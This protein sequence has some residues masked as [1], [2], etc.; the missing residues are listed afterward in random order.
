MKLLNI[1]QLYLELSHNEIIKYI[2]IIFYYN[3]I[4]LK[5]SI[6]FI[7]YFKVTALNCAIEHEYIDIVKL[8]LSNENID[9]NFPYISKNKIFINEISK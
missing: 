2:S 3:K 8:L 5:N 4:I 1:F 6:I 9:I 7:F